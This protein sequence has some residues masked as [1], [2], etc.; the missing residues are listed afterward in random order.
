MNPKRVEMLSIQY[1][2]EELLNNSDRIEPLISENDKEPSYDGQ[3]LLYEDSSF[4]KTGLKKIPIQVK[5]SC[6]KKTFLN[7]NTIKF[8]VSKI[9]LQNY[10]NHNGV[11]YLVV[12]LNENGDYKIFYK[13]LLPADINSILNEMKNQK[14]KSINFYSFDN[15]LSILDLFHKNQTMHSSCS[16]YTDDFKHL[17]VDSIVFNSVNP[18][19]KN[20][21][22]TPFIL[23]GILKNPSE[24]PIPL[25]RFSVIET[26]YNVDAN[27]SIND[28]KYYEKIQIIQKKDCS[29]TKIGNAFE[30]KIPHEPDNINFSIN[31]KGSFQHRIQ[32]LPFVKA[33]I[34]NKK[35]NIKDSVF[36]FELNP[37]DIKHFENEI[38]FLEKIQCLYDI[39]NIQKD[40]N[41]DSISDKD[42]DILSGLIDYFVNNNK[43]ALKINNFEHNGF[44]ETHVGNLYF[45]FIAFKKENEDI[46]IYDFLNNN[47]DLTSKFGDT[48]APYYAALAV[49][50]L[51]SLCNLDIDLIYNELINFKPTDTSNYLNILNTFLLKII[52]SFDQT[53]NL[54]ILKTCQKLSEFLLSKELNNIL[55]K[56]NKYQIDLRLGA[57][58]YPEKTL[59]DILSIEDL[60]TLE[61][62]INKHE[63]KEFLLIA[64][65]ILN[66][67]KDKTKYYLQQLK[68]KDKTMFESFPIYNLYK[69]LEKKSCTN[70]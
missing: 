39:L 13:D 51:S 12:Y 48:I 55:F 46:L 19:N 31:F 62:Q 37:T 56:I 36:P 1:L 49:D 61:N 22:D 21:F 10:K 54:K 69:K 4:N 7:T 43:N 17:D 33:L 42:L 63:N 20:F 41:L 58:I 9:D 2:K 68:N 66:G 32:D 14:K 23:Y 29:I 70:T 50:D 35:F 15:I 30:I 67:D 16:I 34:K 59:K 5:G 24:I 25:N 53:S 6:R 11:L 38:E 26:K 28:H 44:G 57:K 3:I 40:L 47:L 45:K 60:I 18:F 8:S 65:N 27:I 64:I 52:H